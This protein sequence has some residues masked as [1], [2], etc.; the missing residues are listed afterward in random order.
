VYS[1]A[2]KYTY[3]KEHVLGGAGTNGRATPS[4]WFLEVGDQRGFSGFCLIEKGKIVG[5]EGAGLE[6]LGKK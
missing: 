4:R 5:G 6:V 3:I 2:H 1:S